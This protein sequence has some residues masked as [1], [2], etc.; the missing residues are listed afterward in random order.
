MSSS[1]NVSAN[2]SHGHRAV[3]VAVNRPAADPAVVQ[4]AAIRA[5]MAQGYVPVR[6]LTGKVMGVWGAALL[7]DA[8]GH[9][10]PL[11]VGHVVAPGEMVL[12]AQ[13]GIVQIAAAKTPA[14]A[15]IE[16]V[17]AE[18]D[19]GQADAAP[20]AG[21]QGGDGGDLQPGLRVDRISESVTPA[22]IGTEPIS[23]PSSEFRDDE[24]GSAPSTQTPIPSNT[25]TPDLVTVPED[26]SVS[27]D[28]RVN[29]SFQGGGSPAVQTVAGQAISVGNPVV[30]PQGT[31]T[32]NDDGTLSFKP[33]PDFNGS[34]NI[35]YTVDDGSGQPVTSTIVITVTPVN[36]SPVAVDDTA[37]T[38]EGTPLVIDLRSNDTDADGDPLT[39]TEIDGQ[40]IGAQSPVTLTDGQ[41]HP[42]GTVSLNDDG[43]VT[44]TPAPGYRG[45]ATFDYTLRD[46]QGGTD[47][48]RTT[49]IVEAVDDRPLTGSD[50]FATSED[51]AITGNLGTNDTL[52]ADGGNVF[53]VGTGPAHGTVVVNADGTF[54]Y[55]PAANYNGPDSFTYTLTDADGDVSTATVTLNVGAIDDLPTAKNDTFSAT[56]DTA[57]TGNLAS[58][59][60]LSGD[61]GNVFAVGTGP[62]HGTVV[63]NA[64]GTFTY[65][66]AANYNGPDSFTY[67]L[68]DADGDVSTATVTLNVGS[69]DDL[70]TA[71]N[72]T[73]AAT[74][75]TALTGNL[76]S[77]DTLSGDGGNIFAVGTGPAHGTVVVN[78]DGT[79]T[80]TPAANYNGPDSFTYTLTDADGDVSTATV[81]LNVGSVDDLPTA[82]NDTYA[83]TE[84]TAF[85]G[86]LASNDTLSGDG[87]NVFAVGTGPAHGNVV[88]NADGTFTYTPA[89]NYNGP[90]SFTYT[91][92]DADGDVSTAT[93]TL[94]VGAVDDLPTAK[95]D[96]F[97]ATEDAA[98]TGNLASNDT[99]SG[100]GGNVFAVG[101]GPAHGTVVVNADGTFTY[102]PAA[103]YNGPDSFTYTL[104]DADGDVS[105][106]T[107]TLNVGS[108]DD[109]PTAK[110]DTLAATEDTALTGNLAS[111]DTL[112]GDGGNVFA[113][114]TGP[115][116]G[117]VIVNADGT[118][119]YTP[120]ANYNGPDSFTYTLTDADGDGSTATVTLNVGAVDDLPAAN[121][122]T[123][124]ATEDTALTGNLASNDT[125]S[126]D[127]G[128]VFAVSTGPAH[129]TVVVNADGTF[130][131]T[132]AANYNGPDSF[133][134][135]LTDADGDVSTATVTLNVGAVDDL[136]TAK[137]DT[138]AATE[139]TALTG[140]LASND[141]ISGDGGNVFAVAT[142]PA[143][144]TVVVNADGTFTYTPA[145]N[146]NG[147]DSFTYTLTDA[148]G[149]ASTATV[150]LNVGAVDDLPAAKNDTFAA[151]ED[152]TLTGNL[153]SNDTLSGDGGNVFAV[154][155]GPA[156]GTVVVNADGTFTY[157][158]AANYNGPDSFTYT[159][160]DADGDVST[161]TV[162]L[163]V[164]SVDDL[165][166]AK[167]DTFAATEDT[168]LTGNLASN[169]TLSGDGGNVFAVA[170]G[171][172]HGTVVVNA[173]G[174]FTY[175]PAANY[176]GP[177]SF[178]Y[179]L[180]DADGDVSTATVTLNVGSVDDV[181]T[182]TNETFAATEDTALT[183]NLASNDTLSGDGG[184]VFAVGTGPAHGTVV[185]NADGTFTYTPAANYNGPDSFTYT[186]IDAD[187]DVSTATVTLNVGE[188]DDLPTA[189][190]DTFA[191]TEDTTL[192]GNLASNDT[193]SGDG[194]N[195][196]AV[197]TGPVHGTVVVN[198]DGT[199]TYTP[200]ANYNGPDSFTYT[201]TDAGGDVSTATVTLNVGSVDDLPTAKNDTFAAT[202]DTAL[203][204]NLASNDTLSGDGGNIFAIGTGPAHGTVVVNA[205]GTFTY[206]PAANYNGPD[207]FTYKL[208][209]ADGDV[210]TA[211]VTLN[212]GAVD[213]LPTAKNDTFAAIEDTALTGNLASNDTLSGDGGNVFAV[214]TGPT[215]GMVVVNADGT[216]TY[217]PAAN[218]NGHD[219]FTYTLTD[220]DGDISTA[221]VTLNVGAIDDL[222][223]AKNDTFSATEDTAFTGNLA[224]NDTLSGDGGNVFA[225][226][227]GPTHGTVVVN[228][229][230]T[231]TYTPAANYNGPDSFTYTLTDADGDV[232]TATVTLNVG[233]VDDLPTAKNDTF[234]ATEDTAL[235][236][237]LATNDTL[238]GDGGNVFAI[239]TRPAH[240]TVVVNADGTF[241]YT[242]A[243]NYNGPDSF[244]YTL[245]DADGDVSTATVTLNVG[246]VDDLP[247]AKNDTFVA[248][249]D[250]ALTGN[251][252]SNDTLS[253]D[254]GN[255]FA[256]GT[257]PAHGTVV[258]NA[259]GTFTYTPA[260]NYN[261]PDSFTYTLTDADGDV[262][263]A[264][265]TLNVGS[266]DDLPTAKNDTFSAV[267]D[268]AL[269]GN[270]ASND[271]LSGDGG[272][273]FAIGTGPA[274]G[275]VVVNADGTFTY[276]PAANYNGP[277]S[278]TYT[279]TDADGDVSTATVTLNVG[280]IDDLPT[281]KNDTF[282]AT[283][284][285]ALTGNLA[286]NDTLS[287][288]GGN[289]FAVG[290]GPAHGTVVVNA[291]G[292]FIYTPA[293]NYNG[294]DSFTYTLT[295]AD[296]DVSTATVTL[297][298][299]AVDDL[300]TAKNDTFAATEDNAVTGNLASND[301]L[302][303][304]GGN[305][306]AVGTGPAHG[307]VV[308]N[309]DGTFTYT[310]AANYN[311]P[312]SFTYTL[313]DA[314]EDVSTA[315]VTLN[316]GSVDDLPTAKNDTLAATED[317]ALTGN[318]ASNDTL[319]GDG[320]N[321]FA[322]GT[323]PAHGAVVVNADGTFTYTP[324]ANYNGP[325]SF[326]YTLTDADGDVS[327]ATVTLNVGAVDDLPTAKNDTFAA[328]EDTALTG[329]LASNDTLSGDGGNAFALGTGPAHGTVVVNADGTFTYTPAANY[330]G[331]DSFT[332]TLTDADGDVSTATVTLN[333]GSVDD[334][335][336]AKNDTFAATEDTALTGN[337]AS[338]DTLSGDGGNVFAVG[339]GPAHGTVIV[340]ADG[341]FTYTPAA[342]YN[343]PDSF[344]Y[345]LTDADGD[346]STA[347]VTLNVGAVDDLPAA[348]NDTF[349]ATED[350]AFTGN[351]ASNDTLS[352]DGGNV[353]AI[354]TGPAHGTV[355]VNADGTFTYTPAANY[356]GPDSFTYTLTDADGDVSTATVT[357]NVGAVDDLPT[358]KNDTFT[359]TEDTSL[360]GNLG[361][362][363][364]L[365]GDGGNVFAVGAGPAH[366]AV[367][368]NADGTFTYTPA[369]NYN[370]PDSFTYTL[371]DAD[372]DVSTA[373]VT[374]NVGAVDDLP[375]AK[376]DTFSATEDTT[377]TGNLASNDTLS[378]D[379]GNVFAVA[380]GPAHG[381]V[382]VNA[383]GTFTYT[384][385]ANYNG[386]DSF[387]YTLTDA[388]GD[389]STATVTLNV[390]AV[391]D[392]PTAKNDT[393]S[394]TEDTALTGNLASNDTL[395]GDG[396]NVFAVGTGPAHGTVVVNADGTFTYTPAANYNGP[397]SFTYT[398]T[399]ADG[400]VSTATVTL[401]VAAVNDAPVSAGGAVTGSEDTG[402]VF[403]WAQFNV[404]DV[405]S[406]ASSLGVQITSLP[407]DGTLQFF[408]GTSWVAVSLNQTVSQASIAAGN[409]RFFP[410]ANESGA[411]AFGS[412]GTG[413]LKNDYAQFS[414][415]PTDGTTPGATA[416]MR[417]D[418]TPVA[419]TPSL[420]TKNHSVTVFTTSFET[421]DTGLSQG[422]LNPNTTSTSTLTQTTLAGWTR[423]DTP[424]AYAGGTNVWELWSNG[425]TM[426][427]QSNTQIGISAGTGNGQNWLE[428][429]NAD[430][431][432][433]LVQTL[434]LS[435]SVTTTAGYV[436][437]LSFDYAGR[438]GYSQDFTKITVLVDGVKVASYAGTSGS[439]ALNWENLHFSFVGNGSAQTITIIT[440]ATQFNTNG[441]G[442]MIDDI[443]LTESQGALAG[444][445]AGGTK[446]E[447]ALSG[448]INT[449]LADNDGSES[450]SLTIGGL[451]ANATIVTASHPGGYTVVNGSVTIPA[452][453][454]ASAK[455]Q[456]SSSYLGDLPLT[457]T[458]TSLEPNGST[459]TTTAS[460]NFNIL[461]GAGDVGT[462]GSTHTLSSSTTVLSTATGLHGEYFGYNDT[463]NPGQF[464]NLQSGDGTVGNLDSIADIT[465]IINLRQGGSIVGSSASASTA[466]TDASFNA[467][468]ISYGQSVAVANSLGSNS[469]TPVGNSITTG[470]LYNFLGASNA[471]SDAG[472]LKATSSFGQTTDAI[473]RM[474]GSAYFNAGTYDF[475]VRA[476]DGFSIRLDGQV[477]LQYDA[478]Q[479]PTTR[480]TTVPVAI[481]EGF[482]T[483]EIV[484][485][486]QGGNAEL[487]VQYKP[488]GSATYQTLSLDNLAL[489][490]TENAPALTELQDI[491]EN[492]TVNGQY[493]IR[494]GQEAYGGT[495]ADSITGSEG[496]DV[497]HAGAGNDSINGG[498]AADRLEGGAGN[499]TLTGGLG[500][501]TFRWELADH[502]SHGTPAV[503]TITDFDTRGYTSG[504]DRLDLRDLLV[505]ENS[506]NLGNFISFEK[507]GSNTVLHISS[508]GGFSGGYNASAEDQTIVLQ[509]VDL[510]NGFSTNA[511]IIQDLL[512]KGKL[513]T[514]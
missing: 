407:A 425:D 395:S 122:D 132:P 207:S 209:D 447:I 102:T 73:F 241:T 261:G 92:T 193:L 147:P 17:I 448:Y 414:F 219:S 161:A 491:I 199:F 347:T 210:S 337:L 285:T 511:Q 508:S 148:D 117:T 378:G 251:L 191:A 305:V 224:S 10:H 59:D 461:V 317:T 257:G 452:S 400:D 282:S 171:P 381:T 154:G 150:T 85:T 437:D 255:V 507:V 268:T 72:D 287:G 134:Y 58:N 201:L 245:T 309:A 61:G 513:V 248:T 494:T 415:K 50:T 283:E 466:A 137:N 119:T 70:P 314:D 214:G 131:Y 483:I 394:A 83:A 38:A 3:H 451:P 81:T 112:S 303:G 273:V 366:G 349:S 364:T 237:N 315:T 419:D 367:V 189:K 2:P 151:T 158:P 334:L 301:T 205:D 256:V 142:G 34:F 479:S 470:S 56:E 127:G 342:N 323:G 179:T 26:G 490:Q 185:V 392:L 433:A 371:T 441:R 421:S 363:D 469:P 53:A 170:T 120:A 465:G 172:A 372:G 45:P 11:K 393:F 221:T 389:V 13:D 514:D 286:S 428:L 434:G 140:N 99:L 398:L 19:Q 149:D 226:G 280:A 223:A 60:T 266:V 299:G 240:G 62:A 462:E 227:T 377:L 90:D 24:T 228:A 254:G 8:D 351:L 276:T 155:S 501:D 139:D 302:S 406:G 379:G 390:G 182:A 184:N 353:F 495:G 107:V 121:N 246:A 438:L 506:G 41:G 202:E 354:G 157:T 439:D 232:S 247:A 100:D 218:Y 208:T 195:V 63:V 123:F 104:T 183:G 345:T 468:S 357:L 236:G 274:H 89:A 399:D 492:P 166:T 289:V 204:G 358:A 410:D 164:G 459:A 57:L 88:V 78:A 188:V 234:A 138:F 498:G 388:D 420:T 118:F 384:S 369:A 324:T 368:V 68:T 271:T 318:L 463:A 130:T 453:E 109:L 436:Y 77:N 424:D 485:W 177:D 196:F 101:T 46:G 190:N 356:N 233:A 430:N 29:D 455:L 284:D 510:T 198:A 348:N 71:K 35:P 160:T 502:G 239:G 429:N 402:L 480:S 326:T 386:P 126:G 14:P 165:P 493:L 216:F 238:S 292:T 297:N 4:D 97:A 277:D 159:L 322:V 91:L 162:T 262:S 141:T 464:Y 124:S 39:I 405:D 497:I 423:V 296:G 321:V 225:V 163:N 474:V 31:L 338:N 331:P 417:I 336:T 12:T 6:Q 48:G 37:T 500:A 143:H 263:T 43:S 343:G 291:D 175:T 504:G 176:N 449:A 36:D 484:Y 111:N 310:P 503:D 16:R 187:G 87:G 458:S 307:T 96:T 341:T 259:D 203:T 450:L 279:L 28:P 22:T 360:T 290:T 473:M 103:N 95:N 215:H 376:N 431:N 220:A 482:H 15:D 320:G 278:F 84:D 411:D 489:L 80:Y 174:T 253:G 422:T 478:N 169:D 249:E 52:S 146:Y 456:I 370:G 361:S 1:E 20:A 128:N 66:P 265:V 113:V 403:T 412:A 264:T 288:D 346:V 94:N 499:D 332:Y 269:T 9:I 454:L 418:I 329:N 186:L 472:S 105:T 294:P 250:T 374:L 44:F 408:N 505:G 365:S 79:F 252:A 258:V 32:L 350:T 496:R 267:E 244:T 5:L 229:D 295:D 135:T 304:D 206:T 192:T 65:T 180:T 194:G 75:D 440:D 444:N 445:A 18:V 47:T 144:G 110:N 145:A 316:V 275:T 382:V 98:F 306:F 116:H 235:T 156:H 217:T 133:T 481:G 173:D 168:A 416:S 21:L 355:V 152:T 512:N 82:N 197:G 443:K 27:F 333:V 391:D 476:D 49:I 108:V 178:T 243:A 115:A 153:A 308:V 114:G 67:T 231:F 54:T 211:T 129:G 442:A 397:D 30:L 312:D 281:A 319:S 40:P 426:A 93:V 42:I 136:P 487:L 409:L 427:N 339:T 212:V 272:N 344:T 387:T 359:A 69:V 74:E 404:S 311:G 446:T 167:N 362:N 457:V 200:A 477:V 300:P 373:T 25:A 213:D 260:A 328:T 51:G 401:N 327:T 380:T 76:T 486:E 383:D 396:G 23:A 222:P 352:G 293:A 86:N 330:N 467:T 509:N 313:T 33:A 435:R 7:R 335:P 471:G 230:G 298:V 413:N 270:L 325:D 106:A 475:Q 432:G 385:T 181:P 340:N 242:P 64:D 460:L 55:T 488:T 125:L 375:T